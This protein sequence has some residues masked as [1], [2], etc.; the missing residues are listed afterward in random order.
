MSGAGETKKEY[1]KPSLTADV[2]VM[3]LGERGLEVL[4]IERA[5]DPFKGSWA[6]PGGFV[7]PKETAAEGAARELEEE[8]GLTKV[9]LTE[10]GVFS[11]PGRDPRGW[12]VSV[13]H[14]ALLPASRRADAEAGDDAAE[15]A[16][17]D[18]VIEEG[19]GFSLTKDGKAV[20]LAFD[21]HDIM[22]KAVASIGARPH[23]HALG[24]LG[25]TFSIEEAARAY[26]A[27]LGHAV[28][29]PRLAVWLEVEGWIKNAAGGRFERGTPPGPRLPPRSR[30]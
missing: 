20:E 10:L 23:D 13:A 28:D 3:A 15:A 12:V 2:V 17:L 29:E 9:E 7:E 5:R 6:L 27:V 24:L 8:T 30:T 4:F 11:K 14:V 1:P 19:G 18:L 25:A 16:W 22:K 26:Q 21:H